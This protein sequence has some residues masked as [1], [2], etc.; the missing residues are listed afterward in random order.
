MDEARL[1]LE[2]MEMS[3]DWR[4]PRDDSPGSLRS[5]GSALRARYGGQVGMDAQMA[6][7]IER[8]DQIPSGPPQP[9][10]AR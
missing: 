8:L 9:S 4:L 10:R 3:V 7:L 5:F 1:V 2:E 6:E